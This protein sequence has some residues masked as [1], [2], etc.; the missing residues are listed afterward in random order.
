MH[1]DIFISYRRLDEQG[2]ISGRD[3]ARLI[4]K[5][6]EIEGYHPFFDYSEIKDDEFDK[7][8]IPAVENCKVFILVLTKDALNRCKNDDDWVR[9]EIETAIKSGSKI[10]NVSPDNTFNGWPNLLPESLLGI[11]NIQISEVHFGSLF[12]LSIKKLIDERI[13]PGLKKETD[14]KCDISSPIIEDDDEF[15]DSFEELQGELS[16]EELYQKGFAL[17]LGR[18]VEKDKAVAISYFEKAAKLGYPKAQRIL[19]TCYSSGDGVKKDA[20]M[21]QYCLEKAANNH[22][23]ISMHA[24]AEKL[25][26]EG[27]YQQAYRYFKAIIDI[28]ELLNQQYKLPDK[29][30]DRK[31]YRSCYLFSIIS[32][33]K[34]YENGYYFKKDYDMAKEWYRKAIALGDKQPMTDLIE[35]IKVETNVSLVDDLP[36]LLSFEEK[37]ELAKRYIW[38]SGLEKSFNKALPILIDCANNGIAKA[39]KALGLIYAKG[40]IKDWYHYGKIIK[41]DC[42]RD[43]GLGFK[44]LHEFVSN[45][46]DGEVFYEIGMLYELGLGTQRDYS[47]A[48]YW[49]KKAIS[50]NYILAAYHLAVLYEYGKIKCSNSNESFFVCIA[51]SNLASLKEWFDYLEIVPQTSLIRETTETYV[52]IHIH[53]DCE[54]MDY[55]QMLLENEGITFKTSISQCYENN[56]ADELV[57]ISN[58]IVKHRSIIENKIRDD[59]M[60]SL[61]RLSPEDF[62]DT[63]SLDSNGKGV[64]AVDLGLPSGTLWGSINAYDVNDKLPGSLYSWWESKSKQSFSWNN[65]FDQLNEATGSF[66]YV[67]QKNDIIII[68]KFGNRNINR[69]ILP[70]IISHLEGD[71]NNSNNSNNSGDAARQCFGDNWTIPG[72]KHFQELIEECDWGWTE[73][74]NV[75]GYKVVGKN[76][77]H[78]FLP[79]M[80]Q[81]KRIGCYWSYS[82]NEKNARYADF[83]FFDEKSVR[84]RTAQRY[85]GLMIR[86]IA[87][88]TNRGDEYLSL[89]FHRYT[90]AHDLAL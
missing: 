24:L 70:N 81:E 14:Y 33:G 58:V 38:G 11:R 45:S 30:S 8:I 40:E 88:M 78:I 59:F 34:M 18:G 86:P 62:L 64:V 1:Y 84:I 83:L 49:Y 21:S 41:V 52:L 60:K 39:Q 85:M 55:C 69:D 71:S 31:T 76:G 5:Q 17:F 47:K 73:K 68:R 23:F 46:K 29:E 28:Y 12:E 4:A 13:I 27:D 25:R 48:L 80:D 61:D 56:E 35:R 53:L 65:Y 66:R 9:R 44:Y 90:D 32:I 57:Y 51:Y 43:Y 16:A 42:K 77:N 3:Q 82:I 79:I 15:V 22:E 10:I 6:L 67:N 54:L 72:H 89:P 75:W 37:Y 19:F 7:V 50:E 74:E 2:N 63:Y 26:N 20:K 36:E 87:V